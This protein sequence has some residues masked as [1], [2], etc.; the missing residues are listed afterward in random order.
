MIQLLEPSKFSPLKFPNVHHCLSFP[1]KILAANA[2]AG[3]KLNEKIANTRNEEA[4]FL[5][6]S[7]FNSL[8]LRRNLVLERKNFEKM[9]GN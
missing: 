3:H 5:T 1:A 6:N 8:K 2:R 9:C 7:T 4:N